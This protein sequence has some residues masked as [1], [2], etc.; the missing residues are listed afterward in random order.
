M[1]IAPPTLA[2]IAMIIV[3]FGP[4]SPTHAIRPIGAATSAQ[5]VFKTLCTE[6]CNYAASNSK[7]NFLKVAVH[8]MCDEI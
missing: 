6:L 1:T 4:S 7:L 8:H 2:V 5:C 3:Q